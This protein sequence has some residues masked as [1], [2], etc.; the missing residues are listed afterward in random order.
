VQS[1]HVMYALDVGRW[2]TGAST[3]EG[4]GGRKRSSTSIDLCNQLV[5]VEGVAIMVVNK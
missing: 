3:L 2:L 4:G 5:Q 1:M